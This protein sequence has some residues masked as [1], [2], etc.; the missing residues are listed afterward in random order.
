MDII[1]KDYIKYCTISKKPYNIKGININNEDV[2]K[3]LFSVGSPAVLKTKTIEFEDV[4]KYPLCVHDI[5]KTKDPEK[6]I[7]QKDIDTTT[8]VDYVIDSLKRMN[9][10]LDNKKKA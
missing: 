6:R 5:D 4:I 7:N 8:L 1:L 10:R 9:K 2:K 3:L